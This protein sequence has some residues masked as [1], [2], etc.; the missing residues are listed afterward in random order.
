MCPCRR[1]KLLACPEGI[2]PPTHSLEGCCSIQL[3]YGQIWFFRFLSNKKAHLRGLLV[4]VVGAERFELPTLWSQTRCA[5][6]LRYAPTRFKPRIIGQKNASFA[7]QQRNF[8]KIFLRP[9]SLGDRCRAARGAKSCP[10]G[11][12]A[13]RCETQCVSGV[14]SLPNWH[15]SAGVSCLQS[16]GGLF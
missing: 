14:Y 1:K 8:C 2:E 3:S 7:W 12:W 9:F 10:Q 5:T 16:S 15:G 11:F 4:L 6:R 13:V